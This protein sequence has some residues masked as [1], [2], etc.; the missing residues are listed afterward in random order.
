VRE[1]SDAA[2]LA[3]GGMTYR[4]IEAWERLKEAGIACL[5]LNVSCPLDL[6]T[7]AVKMAAETGAIVTYEDHH[8]RTGLGSLVANHLAE[9]GISAK[10][11]KLGVRSY[12]RSGKPDD[13]FAEQ[14]LDPESLVEAVKSLI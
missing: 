7:G 4:A 14:G 9:N 2:I 11:K 10:L 12:G 6:D 8:A 5:L 1:G 13:L 3:A